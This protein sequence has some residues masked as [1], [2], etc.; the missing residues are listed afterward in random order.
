MTGLVNHELGF[1]G[2]VVGLSVGGVGLGL[3][4]I[5]L[6]GQSGVEMSG[7]STARVDLLNDA[8][9]AVFD[10][11]SPGG[12][13]DTL[14][15]IVPS[16]AACREFLGT[17]VS[18]VGTDLG[19]PGWRLGP[20]TDVAVS[21]VSPEIGYVADRLGAALRAGPNPDLAFSVVGISVAPHTL[22]GGAIRMPKEDRWVQLF[23]VALLRFVGALSARLSLGD[24][25]SQA[26]LT[27]PG[28]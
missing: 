27:P 23:P 15:V 20:L 11:P 24:A 1:H 14:R 17:S 2:S 13:P 4:R 19:I 28:G 5:G 18:A 6:S 8:F 7:Q 16:E 25:D 26:A 12:V 21:A 9:V 22:L 10:E 3:G